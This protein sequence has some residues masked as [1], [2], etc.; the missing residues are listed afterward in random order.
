MLASFVHRL[1]N[2]VDSCFLPGA[3]MS[4]HRGIVRAIRHCCDV[5]HVGQGA[6]PTSLAQQSDE[7]MLMFNPR[8][9]Y[10]T[11]SASGH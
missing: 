3:I 1:P 2:L 4:G 8:T 6:V 10:D 7:L 11:L 9:D 5:G